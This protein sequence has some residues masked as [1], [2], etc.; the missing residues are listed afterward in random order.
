M[1]VPF[2]DLKRES[3]EMRDSMEE[4]IRGVLDSGRFILGP[5]V[6]A[7][8]HEW[9]RKLGVKHAIGVASGTDAITLALMGLG[10]GPGD[11]VI[12]PANT[13]VP[14]AVGIARSGATI[15]IADCDPDTLMISPGSIRSA[16]TPKTR[17]IV[18]VHL[19]GSAADMAVTREIAD[20]HDLVIVEDCAQAIG[21]KIFGEAAGSGSEAA[22]FSFYPS[23]NLGAY[24]D[25]GCVVTSSRQVY[26]RVRSLRDYGYVGRDRSVELGLNSRLDPMQAAILRAKLPH[27]DEWNQRRR[28]ISDRYRSAFGG[29]GVRVPAIPDYIDHANHL[30]IMMSPER[31]HF[32]SRLDQQG[33]QTGIHYPLPLHM[34]PALSHLGYSAGDFPNAEKACSQV[35]SLPMFPHLTD[36]EVEKVI[37]SVAVAHSEIED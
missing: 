8:E 24:G 6:E 22:A 5:E 32:R 13:C 30:F 35:L 7:F 33:V 21:T 19:Y 36:L 37:D 27:V 1:N 31:D 29:I 25:G 4:G 12:A 28:E 20:E 26:E 11:E 2:G 9:A 14:T 10:I 34:Q 15:R 18:P 17:A 3:L 16:I 23:K